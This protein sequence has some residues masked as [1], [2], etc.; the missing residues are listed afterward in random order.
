MKVFLTVHE[1]AITPYEVFKQI[2]APLVEHPMGWK[3]MKMVEQIEEADSVVTLT[4]N[5]A[6]REMFPPEF[7]NKK[8]SVCNMETREIFLNEDRWRR[9]IPDKSQLPL[10]AYRAYVLQ[11]E[12][13][14]A[15]G[16]GHANPAK[17]AH[18]SSAQKPAPIM[19]QQTLGIGRFS[20]NPFPTSSELANQ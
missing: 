8:L 1:D 2:A 15:L 19:I 13:G 5:G 4:P 7:A 14:H 16:H 6:I 17:A 10:P 20:A 11:H 9:T 12:L 18:P 3:D